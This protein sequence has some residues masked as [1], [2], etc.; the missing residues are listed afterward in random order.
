MKLVTEAENLPWMIEEAPSSGDQ[1]T[2]GGKPTFGTF[3]GKQVGK[4]TLVDQLFTKLEEAEDSM[5]ELLVDIVRREET[6]Y[7][8]TSETDSA[9]YV[10]RVKSKVINSFFPTRQRLLI[11]NLGW[12]GWF[13]PTSD[14][15]SSNG[16]S[17]VSDCAKGEVRTYGRWS[18]SC[19]CAQ[20]N[21]DVSA[22][23]ILDI[24]DACSVFRR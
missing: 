9:F 14:E 20:F 7:S 17:C 5:K 6:A 8:R 10:S 1:G 22:V 3:A 13:C 23:L 24:R 16:E 18:K 2:V 21:Y 12:K 15:G 11:K 4:Q 19:K